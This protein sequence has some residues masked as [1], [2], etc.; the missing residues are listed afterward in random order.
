MYAEFC[1]LFGKKKKEEIQSSVSELEQTEYKCTNKQSYREEEKR[2]N[3]G[4]LRD[5]NMIG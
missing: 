5:R 4:E 1:N 3:Q 2:G